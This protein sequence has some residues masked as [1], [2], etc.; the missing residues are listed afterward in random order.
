MAGIAFSGV[1]KI[2]EIAFKIKEAVKTVKHNEEEC[3]DMERYVSRVTAV[4]KC[5]DDD[6]MET[7]KGEAM[8]GALEDL[9]VSL[10]RAFELVTECQRKDIIRRFFGAG[11][12]AKELHRVQND[13]SRKLQ[14]GDFATNVQTTI[15]VTNIQSASASAPPPP[16]PQPV[17]IDGFR[18]FSFYELKA[19]TNDFSLENKIGTGGSSTIYKG[20]LQEGQVVAIKEHSYNFLSEE[21]RIYDAI[22]ISIKLN[23]ENIVKPLGYCH[24][25]IMVLKL[26]IFDKY[27]EDKDQHFCFVEEYMPNGSME[28]IIN[29]SQLIDWSSRFKIIQGIAQG[30]HYLH[31]E[32]VIHMDIKPSNILLDCDMNPRICDFGVAIKLGRGVDKTTHDSLVGTPTYMAREY[33]TRGHISRKCDVYAFGLTLLETIHSMRISEEHAAPSASLPQYKPGIPG[34]VTWAYDAREAVRMELFDPLCCDTSQ[35]MDIKRC[36]EVGLLCIEHEPK[37]RPAME[38]VISMLKDEIELPALN[39]TEGVRSLHQ[40]QEGPEEPDELLCL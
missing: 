35:L 23:H 16:R 18:Q 34:L 37:D 36:M 15:M 27:V 8:R 22:N 19:A 17:T 13:I 29:G 2:V 24:E 21:N 14:L 4:I 7:M 33:L 30:L 20:I 3:R 39:Q 5:L 28:D 11:A 12:M 32:R 25:V 9:A 1:G 26:D 38:E 40:T 31:E 6:T 10:E